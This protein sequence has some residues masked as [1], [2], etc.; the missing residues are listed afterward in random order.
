M[1]EPSELDSSNAEAELRR[2]LASG[3]SGVSITDQVATLCRKCGVI[4]EL[5]G[6]IWLHLLGVHGRGSNP[7]ETWDTEFDRTDQAQIRVR[8]PMQ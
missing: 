1:A 8:D 3:E 4:P 2:L 6:V 7:L 5:R